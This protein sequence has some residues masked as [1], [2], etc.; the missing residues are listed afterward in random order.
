MAL[1][2][3]VR[4]LKDAG[5]RTAG[6]PNDFALRAIISWRRRIE[7]R[8]RYEVPVFPP[9]RIGYLSHARTFPDGNHSQPDGFAFGVT[10][11]PEQKV[12]GPYTC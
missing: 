6:C 2:C 5:Q 8:R 9:P 12:G 4:N 1:A 7:A 10:G 3:K 11:P